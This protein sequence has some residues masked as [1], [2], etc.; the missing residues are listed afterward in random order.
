MTSRNTSAT[1]VGILAL[2]FYCPSQYVDQD[3]LEKFDKVSTGK[4]TIGLGQKRMSFCT[5]VEDVN[6]LS[7]TV[8]HRLLEKHNIDP[9]LIGCVQVGTESVIDKSKSV[10]TV[11]MQILESSENSD[12]SGVDNINA[13]FGGTQALINAVNYVYSPF[14]D[15][16]LAVVVMADIASYDRGPA[17]CT[18]GAGALALLIGPDAP[19]VLDTVFAFHKTH[20]YDFYKPKGDSEYPVVDGKLSIDCYTDALDKCFL[21]YREKFFKKY[22]KF[23]SLDSFAGICFHAPYCKLVQ[24]SLARLHCLDLLVGDDAGPTNSCWNIFCFSSKIDDYEYRRV[25]KAMLEQSTTMFAKKTQP[26]LFLAEQVGNMYTSSLY[27]GLI[28]LLVNKPLYQLVGKQV[29]M[30]SYGSG[31]VAGMFNLCLSADQAEG[32]KLTT[33]INQLS[34]SVL[35]YVSN[36]RTV[37]TP[38]IFSQWMQIREDAYGKEFGTRTFYT[39]L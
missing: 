27:G 37:Q 3:E 25:E 7:L 28:S 26:S 18:G 22:G 31:S 23:P 34:E 38:E 39:T 21:L 19:I 11:L 13:C 36:Q 29:L 33:M 32:S 20:V 10:S 16:R 6:S 2:E 24:K 35:D 14:W 1:D 5:D 12:V 15:G 4:Y 17:R 8:F 9:K 30:F